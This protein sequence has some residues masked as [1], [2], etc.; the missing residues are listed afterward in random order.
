[1]THWKEFGLRH[2][3]PLSARTQVVEAPDRLRP[4]LEQRYRL[5]AEPLRGIH[6][7]EEIMHGLYERTATGVDTDAIIDAAQVFLASLN[8]EQRG[9][10][11]FAMDAVEW[12]TWLNIHVNFYRHGVMLEELDEAGRRCGLNLLR[13]TLSARGFKQ[14]R[15]IM[16]VNEFLAALT[17]SHDEFGQWP[18]FISIF[19]TPSSE[20]PWGWQIDGH[21]LNLNCV[22][23]GDQLIVAPAFMGSEPCQFDDGPLAGTHLFADEQRAGFNLIRSFSGEQRE[24]G[25]VRPSIAPEALPKNMQHP[26][27][28]RMLAGAFQDNARIEYEGVRGADMSDAQRQLLRSLVG[29]YVGWTRDGHAGVQ[30][31]RV[32]QHLDETWFSWMG[33]TGDEGP[34]YYRVHSPV[35]LVEFDHHPG[36]VFDN[37]MPTPHHIHTVVRAPNG[38]DYGTDWLRQHHEHFDHSHGYHRRR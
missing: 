14:A 13:A 22:V 15:D 28:G 10:T 9:R 18:Y 31:H 12:R 37:L 38:G 16:R 7:G 23:L 6:A 5:L 25:I 2:R 24:R 26:V 17:G 27:D 36:V 30:M 32:E 33:A 11:C 35:V 19:G 29:I 21:H 8:E 20:L 1:M 4:F 34:F 3:V